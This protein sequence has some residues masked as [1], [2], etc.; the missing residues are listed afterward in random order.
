MSTPFPLEEQAQLDRAQPMVDPWTGPPAPHWYSGIGFGDDTAHLTGNL[1]D[2][3]RFS[4]EAIGGPEFKARG[5]AGFP[6]R[7]SPS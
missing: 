2:R 4:F 7:Y 5:F 1:R 3:R 6:S